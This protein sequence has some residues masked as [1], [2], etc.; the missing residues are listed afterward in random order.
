MRKSRGTKLF[1]RA[2]LAFLTLA[3]FLPTLSVAAPLMITTQ[4]FSLTYPEGWSSFAAVKDSSSYSALGIT[5]GGTAFG[6]GEHI[7]N[8]GEVVISS[9]ILSQT[10]LTNYQRLDSTN[11]TLGKYV[12]A[13]RTYKGAAGSKA[14]TASRIKIYIT[15]K[16]NYIFLSYMVYT[17]ASASTA[18]ADQNAAMASLTITATSAIHVVKQNAILN[19]RTSASKNIFDLRGK[20]GANRSARTPLFT[21][22]MRE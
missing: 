12:F 3:I 21:M 7:S 17:T 15:H 19:S 14:D 10:V 11:L 6:V 13:V 2:L 4:D 1:R 5:R 18:V 20:N 16:G 22:G 9:A 8:E